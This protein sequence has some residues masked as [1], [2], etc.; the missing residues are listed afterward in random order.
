MQVPQDIANTIVSA[1]AYADGKRVDEAFTW[2]RREAPL[3]Q[4]KPERYPPFWAVT[5]HADILAVE[6]QHDLFHNGD[7][8][9]HAHTDRRAGQGF[10][11][12]GWQPAHGAHAGAHG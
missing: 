8:F 1:K 2:L 3:V 6:R 11:G 9:R 4:V 5:R 10:A 12:H 7:K